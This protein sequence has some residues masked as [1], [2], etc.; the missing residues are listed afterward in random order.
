MVQASVVQGRCGTGQMWCM[1]VVQCGAGGCDVGEGGAGWCSVVQDE[2]GAGHG[3]E[4]G[5]GCDAGRIWCRRVWCS[6]VQGES[7]AG[8]DVEQGPGGAGR[9]WCRVG[10]GWGAGRWCS[11]YGAGKYDAV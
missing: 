7:G 6:V 9:V 11:G 3:A 8:H 2:S 10:V 1:R 4:R 5:P